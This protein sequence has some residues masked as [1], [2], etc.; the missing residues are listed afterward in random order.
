MPIPFD[1]SQ[2]T[3]L[4]GHGD[5]LS[6]DVFRPYAD[7]DGAAAAAFLIANGAENV[8][9]EDIQTNGQAIGTFRGGFV[10]L[11]TN[12]FFNYSTDLRPGAFDWWFR[13]SGQP[14]VVPA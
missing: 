2:L 6:R 11:S 13:K 4:D 3:P 14:M 12:G 7:L 1:L 5:F 8:V 10:V 9:H